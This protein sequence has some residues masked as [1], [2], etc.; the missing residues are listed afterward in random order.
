MQT[1]LRVQAA[2]R[3]TFTITGVGNGEYIVGNYATSQRYEVVWK[4][5][6]HPLNRYSCMDFRTSGLMTCKHLEAVKNDKVVNK[7]KAYIRNIA[8]CMSI[9]PRDR[10]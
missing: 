3:E 10:G 2:E 1:K 5:M 8:A 4:G 6:D 7:Y 9:I